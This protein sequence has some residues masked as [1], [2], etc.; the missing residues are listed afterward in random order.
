M[1]E[2]KTF[3]NIMAEMMAELPDDV[4]TREGSLIY[5]ACVKQALQLEQAYLAMETVYDNMYTSTQDEE[6]LIQNGEDKGLP[7]KQATKANLKGKFSQEIE[8]GTRFSSGDFNYICTEWISE[9]IYVMECEEAGTV[10]N[11]IGGELIP[12]DFVED[13][14][15]GLLVEVIEPGSDREEI[16]AYRERLMQLYDPKYFGGNRADYDRFIGQIDGVGAVKT[17]R[18]AEGEEFIYPVILAADYTA[19]SQELLEKVQSLVDPEQNHGQGDGIAPIGHKVIV[20]A[21]EIIIIDIE[22]EIAYDTG[23]SY[24]ALHSYMNNAVDEYFTELAKE[25]HKSEQLL[26][27]ISHIESRLLAIEGILDVKDTKLNGNAENI[28]IGYSCIPKRG[29]VNSV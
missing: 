10:G 7:I 1:F 24:Q 4:D 15:G 14:Q 27:R 25:W 5:N 11:K 23:Y 21:V 17:P 6:H 12:I 13:Y 3:D 29:V 22:S 2:N 28:L 9:F 16:E 20:K 19:P 26:V 18:R 8:I